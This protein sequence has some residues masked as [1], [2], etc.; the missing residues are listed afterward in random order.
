MSI[1]SDV[2]SG[3][4]VSFAGGN[5]DQG[6]RTPFQID[7]IAGRKIVTDGH[8]YDVSEGHQH[9]T[10]VSIPSE[11]FAALLEQ[12]Q[13]SGSQPVQAEGL[14]QIKDPNQ[15][16]AGAAFMSWIPGDVFQNMDRYPAYE[17][18]QM[19]EF[20]EQMDLER[21]LKEKYGEGVKLAK[22]PKSG[23]F[24]MLTPGDRFYDQ[25]R[26]GAQAWADMQDW[27]AK[28][29]SDLGAHQDLLGRYEELVSHYNR[30]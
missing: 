23:N 14:T 19:K 12:I 3:Y 2:F 8:Q 20:L 5:T 15:Y 4:K 11:T 29:S 25:V 16:P 22:D 21:Q 26:S 7:H 18:S 24:V 9:G 27:F 6:Q 17:R 1:I 28:T 30:S 13:A 10:R